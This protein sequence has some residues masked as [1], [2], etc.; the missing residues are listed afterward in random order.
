[1]RVG[2]IPV[3]LFSIKE[4]LP[5]LSGRVN[6]ATEPAVRSGVEH[7]IADGLRVDGVLDTTPRQKKRD[8]PS[9]RATSTA[10]TSSMRSVF[11]VD[12]LAGTDRRPAAAAS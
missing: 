8:P 10:T 4:A 11:Q 1:M 7:Q 6:L 3:D 5:Y 2:V 9:A 12:P